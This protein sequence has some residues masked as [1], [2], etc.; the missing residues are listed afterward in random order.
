MK[1]FL[2]ILLLTGCYNKSEKAASITAFSLSLE[3]P[4]FKDMAKVIQLTQGKTTIV[5]DADFDWLNQYKWYLG[6]SRGM[7]YAKREDRGKE[8]KMHRLILGLTDPKIEG[9]H[10]DR[11]GLNNQRNN[12]R[13]ATRSQNCHNRR[14]RINSFSKY[15]GVCFKKQTSKWVARIFTNGKNKHLGYFDLEIEA[16]VAYNNEALNLHGEFANLNVVS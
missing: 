15:K 5:D 2:L 11:D 16:A 10:R 3:Q 7:F 6:S 8:V 4:N 14:S 1:Y 13:V 12:L 9:D